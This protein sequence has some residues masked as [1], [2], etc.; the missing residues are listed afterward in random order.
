[1]SQLQYL[2]K[3]KVLYVYEK[4]SVRALRTELLMQ[5]KFEMPPWSNDRNGGNDYLEIYA[6][7]NASSVYHFNFCFLFHQRSLGLVVATIWHVSMHNFHI[8]GKKR[9]NK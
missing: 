5:L 4:C 2:H 6:T 9:T 7:I 1:M 8:D 3:I